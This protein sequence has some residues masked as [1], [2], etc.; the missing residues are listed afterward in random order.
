MWVGP[1]T[2]R[3]VERTSP[4]GHQQ[5]SFWKMLAVKSPWAW[6]ILTTL[7]VRKRWLE[8]KKC[9]A[10]PLLL[11]GLTM[12]HVNELV[13]HLY[14][15]LE[16]R[17]PWFAFANFILVLL[18]HWIQRRCKDFPT[19]PGA[20]QRWTACFHPLDWISERWNSHPKT[21][22]A[23]ALLWRSNAGIH[24][25]GVAQKSLKEPPTFPWFLQIKLWQNWGRQL[26]QE[27]L[28]LPL[29]RWGTPDLFEFPWAAHL[30]LTLAL[31][32]PLCVFISS[33]D[34]Q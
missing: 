22:I 2:I 11:G 6:M 8:K 30:V 16:A 32:A 9:V 17:V 28:S 23:G 20:L 3:I 25:A 26:S 31:G 33:A 14:K 15:V 18:K 27:Q 21:I 10:R 5:H 7:A 19:V 1:I 29:K 13:V 24:C 12:A 34:E 4:K